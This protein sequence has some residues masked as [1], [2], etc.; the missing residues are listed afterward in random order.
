MK[1]FG[2][3]LNKIIYKS[4]EKS[5][6]KFCVELFKN[7]WK[8]LRI[9][10]EKFEKMSRKFCDFPKILTFFAEYGVL[11][12]LLQ[13]K[14]LKMSQ[15]KNFWSVCAY[16]HFGQKLGNFILCLLPRRLIFKSWHTQKFWNNFSW[17]LKKLSSINAILRKFGKYWIIFKKYFLI[18]RKIFWENLGKYC[19]YFLDIVILYWIKFTETFCQNI[20]IIL[21]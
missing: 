7:F 3:I 8:I 16:V 14:S 20:W 21:I 12:R 15:F 19:R 6:S 10:W 5:L 9:L 17:I 18:A 11:R 1:R 13:G 2:Q 4:Y